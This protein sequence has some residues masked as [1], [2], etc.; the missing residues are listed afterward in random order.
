M[1]A[2]NQGVEN[3]G[4]V[5]IES[6]TYGQYVENATLITMTLFGKMTNRR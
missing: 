5:T 1:I 4:L 6:A 2:K 3:D